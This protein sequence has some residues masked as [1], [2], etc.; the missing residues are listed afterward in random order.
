MNL[1]D[2]GNWMI[3]KGNLT[4]VY[5]TLYHRRERERLSETLRHPIHSINLV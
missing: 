1:G 5:N 2:E 4:L 3:E